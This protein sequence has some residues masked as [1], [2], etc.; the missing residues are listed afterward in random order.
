MIK[1][2]YDEKC[3]LWSVGV[4]MFIM[5]SGAPPFDGGSDKEIIKKVKAGKYNFNAYQWDY[6]SDEAMDL[7]DHLLMMNPAQRYSAED[8]LKHDWFNL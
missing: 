7:I 5:L 3:D 8:A 4:I 1:E 2:E 6:V